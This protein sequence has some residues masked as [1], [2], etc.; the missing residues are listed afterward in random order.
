MTVDGRLWRDTFRPESERLAVP[1]VLS[2][3]SGSQALADH[4]V[5][6]R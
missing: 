5:T 4:V 1:S 6:I 3:S 2:T